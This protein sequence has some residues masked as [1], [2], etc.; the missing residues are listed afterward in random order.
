MFTPAQIAE[1]CQARWVNGD[2]AG[3]AALFHSLKLERLTTLDQASPKDAAFFFSKLYEE[4]LKSTRAGLI[5][6]GEAFVEPLKASGLPAWK[7]AVI[8]AA[9]DPYVSMAKATAEVSKLLSAHDHQVRVSAS[10][11]HPSSVIDP[12]AKIGASVRIGAGVVVEAGASIADGV[13]L[14]PQVYV[15]RGVRIGEDSVLF[16]HVA[17]YEGTRIGKRCRIHANST[18]GSD[19]FGYAPEKDPETKLPVRQVKIYHLGGVFIADEVEIGAGTTVDR[20][21]FGDTEIGE[22][23][24]IDNQV[25]VG[26]NVK[27]GRGAIVCGCAGL[28]GGSTL[29]DF[30]ILGPQAGLA[31]KVQVGEY[32][33]IASYSAPTKDVPAHSELAGYPARPMK[34]HFRLLALQQKLLRERKKK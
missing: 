17:V 7:N 30:S 1:W 13:V 28:A 29:G 12:S 14:Y 9:K 24:K 11:I 21:T 10:E 22:G 15:G 5:V 19:G 32:S 26:H 18:I 34:E 2:E 25:Q 4:E 31:T 3:P 20:G 6:T 27:I 33:V 16:P 23:A 8:L